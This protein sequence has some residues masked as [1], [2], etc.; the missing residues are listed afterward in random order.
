M[1]KRSSFLAFLAGS[2]PTLTVVASMDTLNGFNHQTSLALGNDSTPCQQIAGAVSSASEVYYSPE[3]VYV[4]D[5]HHYA[6]TSMDTALCS[7]DPGSAEDIAIILQI[8]GSTRTPFAVKGGGHMMNPGSSSTIGVQIAMSRFKQVQYNPEARTVSVGGGLRWDDVYEA[9]EP[10]EVNVVGGRA[11]GVGV[12]GFTLGGGYSWLTNEHGLT[13]DNVIAYEMVLPNGTIT[14][15]TEASDPDLFFGMKGGYNNFGI[16]TSFVMKTYPQGPVWGG[17]VV[18]M[19]TDNNLDAVNAATANFAA[20][21]TDPK[22]SAIMAYS[23]LGGHTLVAMLLFYNGPTPPDGIFDEYLAIPFVQKDVSTRSFLS[24]IQTTATEKT[25]GFRGYYATVSLQAIT[26]PVLETVTSELLSWTETLA[27]SSMFALSYDVE[28]FL[29]TILT[30]GSP[31]AYPPHRERAY[32][33][34]N[35]WFGWSDAADD[36]VMYDAMV[37]SAQKITDA[38]V[39]DGQTDVPL[40]PRYPNYALFGT[41]PALMYGKSMEK[42]VRLKYQY[43]P[44]DVMGLAGGWKF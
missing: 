14:T 32:L 22:A 9:L 24:L 43:D 44:Q 31:S 15:V 23:H 19:D 25:A 39:A 20:K 38:A 33:P 13:F 17:H 41:D 36:Q 8:L 1:G 4:A 10:L 3:A 27:N 7:V 34:L 26:T 40:A 28:P 12:A 30:H 6:V 37:E 21:V 5:I 18:V 11:T 42:L 35:L 29:P 16:V 2:L